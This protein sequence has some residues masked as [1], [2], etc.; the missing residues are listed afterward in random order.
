MHCV[1]A[2]PLLDFF[3][4]K[5]V[6]GHFPP[7]SAESSKKGLGDADQTSITIGL[8]RRSLIRLHLD[9]F[10]N[11]ILLKN[12]LQDVNAWMTRVNR[13]PNDFIFML[14]S[15]G[16]DAICECDICITEKNIIIFFKFTCIKLG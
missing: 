9:W 10:L 4:R 2:E 15:Q 16:I 12:P 6:Q 11:A 5:Q 7:F 1:C 3:V 8:E 13:L 14:A